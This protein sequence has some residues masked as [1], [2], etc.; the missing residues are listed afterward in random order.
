V[1]VYYA[2][3]Y[4]VGGLHTHGGDLE[5]HYDPMPEGLTK[6]WEI[7]P[8]DP[9]DTTPWVR[10]DDDVWTV[11][12]EGDEGLA[13]SWIELLDDFGPLTDDETDAAIGMEALHDR[14]RITSYTQTLA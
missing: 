4:A 5:T 14:E 10:G 12:S 11:E 3:P 9:N 7:D 1:T 8:A 2:T 13:L 6:V